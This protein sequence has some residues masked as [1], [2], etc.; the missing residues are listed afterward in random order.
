MAATQKSTSEIAK[1]KK[2]NHVPWSEEYEKMISGMLYVLNVQ[3]IKPDLTA[4]K[5]QFVGS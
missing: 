5:V 1:A 2:L 4:G 3:P